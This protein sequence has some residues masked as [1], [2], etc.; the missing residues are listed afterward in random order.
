MTAPR[1]HP[2]ERA[3][4]FDATPELWSLYETHGRTILP[5]LEPHF[6]DPAPED[7]PAL[8]SGFTGVL[9]GHTRMPASVL[10]S[11]PD[12]RH[13]V[14]LGT[15][16]STYVDLDAAE[17]LGIEVHAIAGYGSR[18]IAE[19]S[20]GLMFA[21]VRHI[22]AHDRQLRAGAWVRR[23]G[24]EL[25]GK[26]L[27]VL[28]CGSV[29]REVIKLGAALGLT[30]L[31]WNRS[32]VPSELPCRSVSLDAVLAESDV[33]TV[34]VAET[35]QTAGL[36]GAER[37]ALMQPH[38]V[39]INT[40]RGNIIDEHALLEALRNGSIA[41]A[42][43]D[44]YSEEPLPAGHPFVELENVT[45]TAHNA[46]NSPEASQRLMTMA[47]ARMRDALAREES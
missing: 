9:N 19:H 15:G 34:H 42:A 32:E 46:W 39:L 20:I 10:E 18:T 24:F 47:L 25:A 8:V 44:V 6:G 1:S 33:L 36:I 14:F 41:H 29:G 37:L 5:A 38:A 2:A 3:I 4:Y 12:L 16:A 40:A 28:G 45:L 22:A 7:I 35:S 31:A 21:A 17:S 11:C 13:V 26:T 43:L 27:G 23:P 30:V